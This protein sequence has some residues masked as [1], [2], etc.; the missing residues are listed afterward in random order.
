MN[1]LLG[2]GLIVVGLLTVIIQIKNYY[3]GSYA[4]G[5]YRQIFI[6]IGIG[7]IALGIIAIVKYFSS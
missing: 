2:F 3:K 1:I 7:L 6:L 4:A 5:M